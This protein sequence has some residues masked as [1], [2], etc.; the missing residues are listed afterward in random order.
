M[1]PTIVA[2]WIHDLEPHARTPVDAN[3][4]DAIN[5]LIEDDDDD[6]QSRS[7]TRS[8]TQSQASSCSTSP[9]KITSLWDVGN[10]VHIT[11]LVDEFGERREQLGEN[12][13]ALLEKLEYLYN[14]PVVPAKLRHQPPAADMRWAKPHQ[15][16]P[17]DQRPMDESLWELRTI[18]NI[19]SLSHRCVKDRDLESEWNHR[20]HTEVLKLAFGNDETSVGFRSV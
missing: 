5:E 18:R 10:G 19:V 16:D 4:P 14:A 2:V 7:L 15:F 1:H 20:V 17:S 13:L 12:G 6:F 11:P 9:M 3:S 8:Y